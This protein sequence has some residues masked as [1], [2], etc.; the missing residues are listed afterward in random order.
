MVWT[1][2]FGVLVWGL[3]F[4]GSGARP[5]CGVHRGAQAVRSARGWVARRR[6][7]ALHEQ[8][9]VRLERSASTLVPQMCA[10]RWL[11][12]S[13][14]PSVGSSSEVN[15]EMEEGLEEGLEAVLVREAHALDL[16]L[17]EQSSWRLPALRTVSQPP[18]R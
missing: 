15:L 10:A 8:E 18:P 1:L 4:P 17:T 13:E 5:G 6:L 3:E 7:V 12:P 9:A 16:F 2:G 14:L 11:L